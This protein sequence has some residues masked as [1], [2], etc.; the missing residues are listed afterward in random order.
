MND[1]VVTY[2]GGSSVTTRKFK[3]IMDFMDK[4]ESGKN[5]IPTR[6]ELQAQFFENPFNTKTFTGVGELY[7]HC[8]EITK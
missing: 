8:R 3:T 2:R 7:R 5:D 4:V 1:L 6:M